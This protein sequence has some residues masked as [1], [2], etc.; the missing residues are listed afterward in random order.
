MFGVIENHQSLVKYFLLFIIFSIA[1]WGIGGYLNLVDNRN[2]QYVAKVGS[3]E[4]AQR[5]VDDMVSQLNQDN[6]ENQD[7]NK[8]QLLEDQ[9]IKHLINRHLLLNEIDH[10]DIGL[11]KK[12]LVDEIKSVS[13]FQGNDGKFDLNKYKQFLSNASINID[14]FERN[15]KQQII[16][17]QLV[18]FFTKYSSVQNDALAN[19]F[20]YYAI[21]SSINQ[22][23]NSSSIPIDK[24]YKID[25]FIS[26]YSD[27]NYF[28][29]SQLIN[30]ANLNQVVF[31]IIRNGW[32][33]NFDVYLRYLR[34]NY[35]IDYS[36]KA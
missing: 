22:A 14:D 8:K 27:T 6:K 20:S 19:Q 31:G 16:L 18:D 32:H 28:K 10:M 33:I 12:S 7:I 4:I 2:S 26:M 17:K 35:Q 24:L 11:D 29:N 1:L 36:K 30:N 25:D 15:V 34:S 9:A 23:V 21:Q 5:E 3:Q 13:I